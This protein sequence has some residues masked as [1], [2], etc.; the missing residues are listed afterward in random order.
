MVRVLHVVDSMDRAGQETFIM[1]VYRA[2]DRSKVQFDFLQFQ[3]G[4]ADFDEE[5]LALGGKLHYAIHKRQGL[6]ASMDQI[7]QVVADGQYKIVH[8]HYSNASMAI[9]LM[10]AKRGGATCL[11]SHSHNTSSNNVA[12]HKLLRFP[13]YRVSNWHLACSE[14][15][16]EWMFGEKPFHVIPNGIDREKFTYNA[17]AAK[18]IR[19]EFDIA[20]DQLVFGHVGRFSEVKNHKFIL[21]IFREIVEIEPSSRLLLVG[22]GPL[23]P[24][25]EQWVKLNQLDEHVHF[26][27]VRDDVA[28]ILSALNCFLMPSLYEGL[29]V[30]LVEAQATGLPC[31]VSDN[32][33]KEIAITQ[34]IEQ[35][36]LEEA[37]RVWAVK[38]IE[39]S[40]WPRIDT[41]EDIKRSG[42]DIKDVAM[43]L[44]NLYLEAA[45]KSKK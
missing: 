34:L 32:I 5:I 31:L 11:I 12:M 8:R 43:T 39:M 22:T 44:Q 27:G 1:N 13:L 20:E 9:D 23:R 30:T 38:A 18:R 45:N 37:A 35:L 6:K 17:T 29:P 19:E 15:A 7:K 42:Y 33:T 4:P 28:D 14:G 3:E 40:V 16:G 41:T 2:M 21:E 26:L 25:M 24:A 36:N 10:A